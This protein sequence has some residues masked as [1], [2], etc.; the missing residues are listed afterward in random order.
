MIN[1]PSLRPLGQEVKTPPFHGGIV[2]SIPA[3]VTKSNPVELFVRLGF[4]LSKF[5]FGYDM[6]NCDRDGINFTQNK[7]PTVR[8]GIVGIYAV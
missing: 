6:F 2:G 4:C 1:Y 3:G 5:L 7:I 8:V